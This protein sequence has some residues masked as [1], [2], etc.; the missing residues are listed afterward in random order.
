MPLLDLTRRLE[1]KDDLHMNQAIIGKLKL[2]LQQKK[3]NIAKETDQKKRKQMEFSSSAIQKGIK[4]ISEWEEPIPDGSYAKNNIKGVGE[5]IA[6]RIDEIIQT[7]TLN[8]LNEQVDPEAQLILEL[9]RVPGVGNSNARRLIQEYRIKSL[10]DFRHRFQDK[11]LKEQKGCLTHAMVVGLTHF[12]DLQYRISKREIIKISEY[13]EKKFNSISEDIKFKICGSYR[14]GM[15]TSGDIDVLV[16]HPEWGGT[17]ALKKIIR[18]LVKSK[19]LVDHL[20][21]KHTTKYMGMCK[22]KKRVRHIDIRFIPEESWA[23]ATLYFTGSAD[24]NKEMRIIAADKGM[25]LNEY[26]LYNRTTDKHIKANTE[27]KIFSKLKIKY[28]KPTERNI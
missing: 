9:C 7:G 4:L 5:G 10:D 27:K 21:E 11:E 6:K 16:T 3:Q 15:K 19:F 1:K 22:L 8:E 20:T 18:L 25:L 2:L 17:K 14:R 23:A 28:L 12:D 26:G 13:L 24:L